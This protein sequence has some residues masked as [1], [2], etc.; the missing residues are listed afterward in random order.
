VYAFTAGPLRAA[1]RRLS[2]ANSQ[3]EEYLPDVVG[4]YVAAGRPVAAMRAPAAETAGVNDRVQL[5]AAGRAYNDR[6]LEHWMRS[7]VT[8]LDPATTWVDAAVRL[9]PDVTVLPQTQ[10]TGGT[11]VDRGAVIG[12]DT[13]LID[14]V[15]GAGA[16]VVRAHCEGAEIGP[17]ATVGPYTYLRPGTRLGRR[18]KAGSYVEIKSSEVGEGSKV[19]HLSYVGDTTIGAGSNIGA[20]AIVANYDG[21]AKH[22]TAVGDHVRIGSDTVLVAP[23]TV[24]DGGYTAAGSVIISD[25]P[26]GALGVGRARQRNVPGW[27]AL[28]RPGTPSAAAARAATGIAQAAAETQ[29]AE[30]G[31][32]APGADPAGSGRHDGTAAE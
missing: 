10:L 12:P 13:T 21:V 7:G 25:V 4:D 26:A 6:V 11:T 28:R 27:V 31:G 30:P 2:T 5:A 14:C 17:E 24:G 18:A 32:G 19:P 22:R 20:G 15:V 9:A 16:R 1:L 23:V 29:E 8:V 3:G